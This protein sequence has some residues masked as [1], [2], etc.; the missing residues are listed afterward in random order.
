[1]CGKRIVEFTEQDWIFRQRHICLLRMFAVIQTDTNDFPRLR[2]TRSVYN[3]RFLYV[4]LL[5][6]RFRKVLPELA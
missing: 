3:F 4:T 1:M 5:F 2:H 6:L